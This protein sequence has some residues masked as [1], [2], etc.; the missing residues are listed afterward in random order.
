MFWVWFSL[1]GKKVFGMFCDSSTKNEN[2][3]WKLLILNADHTMG[4]G[5]FLGR[6]VRKESKKK[7]GNYLVFWELNKSQIY[8]IC[9]QRYMLHGYNSF[10]FF[11]TIYL[12]KTDPEFLYF[13][14]RMPGYFFMHLLNLIDCSY[15]LVSPLFSYTGDP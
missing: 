14:S 8:Q 12:E 4:I 15:P 2:I 5:R 9:L 3:G 6:Q 13:M 11:F 1:W 7:V 10:Y